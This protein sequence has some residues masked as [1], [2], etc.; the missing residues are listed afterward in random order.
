MISRRHL[1]YG[2]LGI[3]GLAALRL[4]RTRPED[5]IESVLRKRLDYLVLEPAG[6]A[7][8]LQALS[9]T[10]ASRYGVLAVRLQHLVDSYA[11]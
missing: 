6:V 3:V 8:L 10:L 4:G 9:D 11:L 5:A 7:A 1:L 2:G